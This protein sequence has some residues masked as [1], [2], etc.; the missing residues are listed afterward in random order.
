[1]LGVGCWLE[2]GDPG[3]FPFWEN[4]NARFVRS[5]T[6]AVGSSGATSPEDNAIRRQRSGTIA[7][8]ASRAWSLLLLF[9]PRQK[10]HL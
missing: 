8:L 9:G 1:M 10:I 2:L 4:G 5:Q 6:A 7:T 3:M